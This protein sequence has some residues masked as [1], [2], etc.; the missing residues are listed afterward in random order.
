MYHG[1]AGRFTVP[2]V[3]SHNEGKGTFITEKDMT[4]SDFEKAITEK[5]FE[6]LDSNE[7]IEELDGLLDQAIREGMSTRDAC[8]FFND[9]LQDISVRA[10]ELKV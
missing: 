4:E 2:A 9:T 6:A 1:A 8:K 5:F 7:A 3:S 10:E